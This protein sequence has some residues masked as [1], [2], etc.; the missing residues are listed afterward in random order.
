MWLMSSFEGW[1][2]DQ[3]GVPCVETIKQVGKI[4]CRVGK[5]D[6]MLLV[7][8][9]QMKLL[10]NYMKGF[11]ARYHQ[12]NHGYGYAYHGNHSQNN[13]IVDD[14]IFEWEMKEEV[15]GELIADVFWKGG[16][17]R[18][19]GGSPAAST[20]LKDLRIVGKPSG[21][22]LRQ[23]ANCRLVTDVNQCAWE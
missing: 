23:S 9:K 22:A 3:E 17:P 1:S 16:I 19:A 12:A 5:K 13:A 15:V 14:D 8:M 10:M 7:M 4:W 21:E 2:L 6:A 20:A 11:H 18:T